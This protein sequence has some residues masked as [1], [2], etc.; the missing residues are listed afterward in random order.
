MKKRL[1]LIVALLIIIFSAIIIYCINKKNKNDILQTGMGSFYSEAWYGDNYIFKCRNNIMYVYDIASGECMP[2]CSDPDCKH[3]DSRC[4]ARSPESKL[5]WER[6]FIYNNSLYEI[7]SM[8]NHFEIYTADKD[9][10]NRKLIAQNDDYGIKGTSS[11]CAD[12]GKLYICVYKDNYDE[13]TNEVTSSC[14]IAKLDL[15]EEEMNIIELD[16]SLM[17]SGFTVY[18]NDIY[19]WLTYSD[20]TGIYKL[21][22][23]DPELIMDAGNDE[24]IFPIGFGKKAFYYQKINGDSKEGLYKYSIADK[25][26]QKITEISQ[27]ITSI[28]ENGNDVFMTTLSS[29]DGVFDPENIMAINCLSDGNLRECIRNSPQ[30]N[31][32]LQTISGDNAYIV[33]TPNTGWSDREEYFYIPVSD[34]KNGRINNMVKLEG[35]PFDMRD[36]EEPESNDSYNISDGTDA[37]TDDNA[38]YYSQEVDLEKEDSSYFDGKTKL[39][40]ALS[41]SSDDKN[42]IQNEVNKYLDEKGYDFAVKFIYHEENQIKNDGTEIIEP[43][44]EYY[45]KALQNGEQIDIISSG[46][47]FDGAYSYRKFVD[48]GYF[49]PLNKYFD[50]D[51]GKK[52]YDYYPE[53]YWQ[54]LSD[55]NGMI[56]GRGFFP[57]GAHCVGLSVNTQ[58]A[59]EFGVDVSNFDGTLNG[60]EKFLKYAKDI[61]GMP[62][63]FID[64]TVFV[65]YE[66]AGFISFNGVFF[67]TNTN[68]F[69]NLFGSKECS[70]Y[71]K[72]LDSFKK[73]GFITTD[74][75]PM[76]HET[77]VL[78]TGLITPTSYLSNDSYLTVTPYTNG[79]YLNFVQG[80]TS[81][82]KEPEKAFELLALCTV[83]KEL[84]NIIY[85]GTDG[86]NYKY[87]ENGRMIKNLEARA[88]DD[89]QDTPANYIIADSAAYECT[90]KQQLFTELSKSIRT[91]PLTGFDPK[92]DTIKDKI[93]K[94]SG[95]YENYY[96]L[97]YAS[98]GEYDSLDAAFEDINKQLHDAGIDDVVT[99]LNKQY[100]E[101]REGKNGTDNK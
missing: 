57:L 2:L 59:E 97:F 26:S 58:A 24:S 36:N 49:I 15:D 71:L 27:Y 40:W 3:N 93:D 68:E 81:S 25:E 79:R 99:E 29:P 54:S 88:Y 7:F 11:Y 20:K 39:V 35:V 77:A 17:L 85:N 42:H 16:E 69:E 33:R 94:C 52:L 87:N 10:G 45:E 74:D 23:S 13:I 18:D 37:V 22:A 50:T 95:I 90:D 51:L 53:W 80:I 41:E 65:Y 98:Y 63:L 14:A 55:E 76:T 66:N 83:D 89:Y 38:F 78:S 12:D 9:G 67:N 60:L 43:M 19:T 47:G 101:F 5:G 56:Y 73:Q 96:R 62:V 64:P 31:Y 84:A 46:A 75:S 86:R 34:L 4:S 32:S 91:S 1:V 82:C 72:M 44:R 6:V 70:E 30:Y 61:T 28:I 8:G 100:Q 48:D 92:L 21:S